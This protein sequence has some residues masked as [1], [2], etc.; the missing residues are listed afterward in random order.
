[1]EKYKKMLRLFAVL[2]LFA[3]IQAYTPEAL[4]D[5]IETLPGAEKLELKF[6]HFSGYLDIPGISG[7]FHF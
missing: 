7:S 4:I 3:S 5:K 2:S 1:L 6:N